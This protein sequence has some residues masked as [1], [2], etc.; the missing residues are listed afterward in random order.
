MLLSYVPYK[1]GLKFKHHQFYKD[2][3]RKLRNEY[4]KNRDE[5]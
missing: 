5:G 1:D 4:S 3:H 2:E